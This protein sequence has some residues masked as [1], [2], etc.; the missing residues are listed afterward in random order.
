MTE[1][2]ESFNRKLRERHYQG[3]WELRRGMEEGEEDAGLI[4]HVWEWEEVSGYLAEAM[5]VVSL[6]E[7]PQGARR[8]ILLNNPNHGATSRTI[9]ASIQRVD[10]G[11]TAKAHRHNITAFRFVI[12]GSERMYTVVDGEQFPMLPGDLILTPQMTWHDHVNESDEPAIWLDGLDVP[13]VTG[14]GAAEQEN[15]RTERQPV[16]KPEG[17]SERM[18]GGIRP[19]EGGGEAASS[20]PYRYPWEDTR[21]TL[22]IA[23]GREACHDPFDGVTLEYVNPR[24]GEGPALKTLSLRVQLL[25]AGERTRAHE[26]NTTEVYHV[27]E[28]A[29]S[30][31]VDDD[32]LEWGPRDSFIVP[33]NCQHAHEAGPDGEAILFCVSDSPIFEAFDLY[34]EVAQEADGTA[35]SGASVGAPSQ[36]RS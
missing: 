10:P 9:A 32:R 18:L 33:P 21:E 28:G 23:A 14:L 6:E 22:A 26:H 24:T 27:V 35:A 4:P 34:E 13:F 36:A 29:G 30:T 5:D 16:D 20:T 11:E 17:F 2:L 31:Q 1:E 15:Y 3:Q 12:Q 7:Q 25:E 19:T 8:T